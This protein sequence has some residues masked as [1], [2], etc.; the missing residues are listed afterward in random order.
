MIY[1][2]LSCIRCLS[3]RRATSLL[4]LLIVCIVI[5]LCLIVLTVNR[6]MMDALISEI[7]DKLI[8]KYNFQEY[9][10]QTEMLKYQVNWPIVKRFEMMKT[11]GIIYQDLKTSIIINQQPLECPTFLGFQQEHLNTLFQLP[12][13]CVSNQQMQKEQEKHQFNLFINLLNQLLIPLTW[14]PINDF[15]ISS[16]DSSQFFASCPPFFNIPSFNPH[17]RPWYKNHMEK[18]KSSSEN[19]QVSNIYQ[20]FGTNEYGLTITYSLL[21]SYLGCQEEQRIDG[22]MGYDLSFREIENQLNFKSLSYFLLNNLGQIIHT[23]FIKSFNLKLNE[24]LL[25]IYQYNLTGF[26]ELDWDQIKSQA[27]NQSYLNNCSFHIQHLCRYNSI[28][29]QDIILHVLNLNPDFYLVIFQN[30]T[31][32]QYNIME[33][34]QRKNDIIHSFE[35]YLICLVMASVIFLVFSWIGLYLF[36]RPIKELRQ[37]FLNQLYSKFQSQNSL[38]KMY[39]Q[40]EKKSSYFGLALK[41]LKI[42]INDINSKKC[43]NCHLIEN[44]KY[45]KSQLTSEFYQIRNQIK[46]VNVNENRNLL[47]ESQD[48]NEIVYVSQT[49]KYQELRQ[50]LFSYISSNQTIQSEIDENIQLNNEPIITQRFL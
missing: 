40:F 8:F 5:S 28:Y 36:F 48:Q 4:Q 43:Q 24:S 33:A 19:A 39:T 47:V 9:E 13:F 15:Y 16:T 20:S 26:N 11:F 14:S 12:E 45:P 50:S 49:P 23:N 29:N 17:D 46:F 21:S 32:Q 44:F 10:L 42:K 6:V 27:K 35:T 34:N 41:N 1:K 22:V 3:L 7:S 38:M 30:V 2:L 25:Y 37:V 18:S 31:I